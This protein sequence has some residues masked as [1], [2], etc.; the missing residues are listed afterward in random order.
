MIPTKKL[1]EIIKYDFGMMLNQEKRM[2]GLVE[3]L[4][5]YEP[6]CPEADENGR[7]E[8]PAASRLY[9]WPTC[10]KCKKRKPV[11]HR[12]ED[13]GISSHNVIVARW[14]CTECIAEAAIRRL[15]KANSKNP[16][17]LKEKKELI[18]HLVSFLAKKDQVDCLLKEFF[19]DLENDI[20]V[21]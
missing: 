5:K 6:E 14:L 1:I 15:K 18:D 10:Q 2:M 13:W 21:F 19:Q 16:E 11:L 4:L 17:V 20:V 8:W 3:D 12:I 7:Y 9:E